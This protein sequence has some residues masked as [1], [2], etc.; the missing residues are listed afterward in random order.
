[1]G[2]CSASTT[3]EN[4]WKERK[5]AL[6]DKY[7]P[8]YICAYACHLAVVANHCRLAKPYVRD[9]FVHSAAVIDNLRD[10]SRSYTQCIVI[11]L[12]GDEGG[13]LALGR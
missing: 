7:W 9:G 1:M 8:P 13:S 12:I 3:I 5:P 6:L 10:R 11:I 2:S 4:V